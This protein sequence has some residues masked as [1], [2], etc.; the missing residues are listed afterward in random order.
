MLEFAR[1]QYLWLFS[2]VALFFIVFFFARRWKKAR[3]T[4]GF[5]WERVAKRIRPPTW[6]RLLRLILTLLISGSMLSSAALY[7]AGL[8]PAKEEQPAPLLLFI[9]ED[10]SPSMRA[11]TGAGTKTT[12]S[13]LARRAAIGWLGAMR[14][15]DRAL[16]L[17][18]NRG[19]PVASHWIAAEERLVN[20]PIPPTDFAKPDMEALARFVRSIAAPPD[21]PPL[22]APQPLFLWLGDSPPAFSPAAPPARLAGLAA[23]DR[24][25]TF[26][27][28]PALVETFG[29]SVEN[30][31]VVEAVYKPAPV[32]SEFA[33]TLQGKLRSGGAA[34]VEITSYREGAVALLEKG[35]PYQ[36]PLQGNRRLVLAG[37]DDAFSW[38]DRVEVPLQAHSLNTVAII[39]PKGEESNTELRQGIGLLIP[40]RTISEFQAGE[41][42]KA[43]IVILDRVSIEVDCRLLLCFGG[44]PP[45]LGEVQAAREAKSGLF[46]SLESP[47]WLGFE[48]P[49]L[50]LLAGREAFPLAPGHKLTAL[51]THVEAGLLI[52]ASRGERDVLYVGY[53][54][55]ESNFLF[56][57]EGPTLLQRWLNAVLGRERVVIPPFCRTEP[58][59]EVKLDS[60]APMRI[61][62]LKG[63]ANAIGATEYEILPSPDGRAWIGP[64]EQPGDY[65]ATQ[66]GRTLGR[67]S[68]YWVD[69]AEQALPYTPL[70]P[71]DFRKLAP[72]QSDGWIN[73]FPAILLWVALLGLLLEW[74]LWLAGLTD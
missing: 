18:F 62:L 12:R 64:F 32:G 56:V 37:K 33:G 8:G 15:E 47:S 42:F 49:N 59:I 5:I 43:D 70:E 11:E 34:S 6:K 50:Q 7:A 9:I 1:D 74:L 13:A 61:K 51:A 23:R 16:L 4:Y 69:E 65:Q 52:A 53:S 28:I 54:P 60:P 2:L 48:V 26:A 22:P 30:D 25:R 29:S 66:L 44:L 20:T 35:T 55:T 67:I 19:R 17:H 24:W 63:W 40:G 10:N 27:E 72:A 31:A 38:D 73:W 3:V 36:V 21:I 71:L 68:V 58:G 14:G 57:P 39:R 41:S 46:S 45:A